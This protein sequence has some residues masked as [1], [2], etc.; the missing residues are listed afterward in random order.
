MYAC[1]RLYMELL[2]AR[3]SYKIYN[4]IKQKNVRAHANRFEEQPR[5]IYLAR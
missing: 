3:P 1:M 5:H 2:R 4:D